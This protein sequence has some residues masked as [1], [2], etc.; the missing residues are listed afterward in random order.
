MRLVK[1]RCNHA[2][3]S[4]HVARAPGQACPHLIAHLIPALNA[5]AP[6]GGV[7]RGPEGWCGGGAQAITSGRRLY[8]NTT[9]ALRLS[10]VV[11]GCEERQNRHKAR[12][13]SFHRISATR[14]Q[15]PVTAAL[16]RWLSVDVLDPVSAV[17]AA[18]A[19]PE[20]LAGA[21]KPQ[22][23][24]PRLCGAVM[25]LLRL[26]LPC[27][28]IARVRA[29][30][31]PAPLYSIAEQRHG[32]PA[33]AGGQICRISPMALQSTAAC[34]GDARRLHGPIRILLQLSV[35]PQHPEICPEL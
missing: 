21:V 11:C 6:R 26:G 29:V 3:L 12:T 20:L 9:S 5:R 27:P 34:E 4:I 10:T 19:C 16:L 8:R 23:Q 14:W 32:S 25:S 24:L 15:I 33:C 28:N 35:L 7:L 31:L 13:A 2:T 30:S 18:L 22:I 1:P 17:C